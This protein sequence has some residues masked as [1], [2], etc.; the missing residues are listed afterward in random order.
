MLSTFI[1][2]RQCF[3]LQ[4]CKKL[5]QKE[6]Q[7]LLTLLCWHSTFTYA[8]V[9]LI[10][11]G[12]WF[13][14]SSNKK[15]LKQGMLP[16]YSALCLQCFPYNTVWEQRLHLLPHWKLLA[17]GAHLYH[18][19][20]PTVVFHPPFPF[21]LQTHVQTDSPEGKYPLLAVA[22]NDLFVSPEKV[23]GWHNAPG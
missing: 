22:L 8:V 23:N 6:P 12:H 3:I 5:F 13:W 14:G 19:N 15:E 9:T 17:G 11:Q 4:I 16:S 1:S 2:I 10:T 18:I 7:M 20:L 21:Y